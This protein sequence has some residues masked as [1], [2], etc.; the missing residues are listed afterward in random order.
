MKRTL[1]AVAAWTLMCGMI[2]TGAFGQKGVGDTDGIARQADKPEIVQLSGTIREVKTGPC[3]K[4][5]GPSREGTHVVLE[6]PSGDKLNIHLGPAVKVGEMVEDLAADQ[7]VTVAAF[8]TDKL[9]KDAYVAQSLTVGAKQIELRDKD[10][11]PV[12]AGSGR[13]QM[14]NQGPRK[15]AGK[16]RWSAGQGAGQ[17]GGCA[18]CRRGQGRG[19]GQGS[20]AAMGRCQGRGCSGGMC[21]RGQ[22]QGRGAGMGRGQGRGPGQG[23]GWGRGAGRGQ[24]QGRGWGRGPRALEADTARQPNNTEPDDE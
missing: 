10:L 4:T 1:I 20:S 17:G 5:T 24:G 11:R 23:Q 12:W 21:G 15:G 7:Q 8:R 14:A 3:E 6:T 18:M 2:C 22:G 9:P 16:G 13:G 19:Q